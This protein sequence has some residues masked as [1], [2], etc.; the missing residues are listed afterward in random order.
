MKTIFLLLFIFLNIFALEKL[1]LTDHSIPKNSKKL[2]ESIEEHAIRLGNG[3]ACKT[4]VFIDPMCQYS[5]KYLTKIMTNEKALEID[6]YYIFLYKL[7]K[8][9]SNWRLPKGICS[10]LGTEYCFLLTYIFSRCA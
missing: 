2:L 7:P 8:Y 9:D 3:K 10:L 4:Y 6:S 1:D 5:K